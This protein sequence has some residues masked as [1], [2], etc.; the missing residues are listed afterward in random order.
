MTADA[1]E[2]LRECRDVVAQA[3]S[4]A[5]P[6]LRDLLK[7]ID[8]HLSAPGREEARE[9]V[10]IRKD[11]YDFLMG[12]GDLD[13]KCLGQRSEGDSAFWWR[14][15]LRSNFT[16]TSTPPAPPSGGQNAVP[17]DRRGGVEKEAPANS[18]GKDRTLN[19]LP[20]GTAPDEGVVELIQEIEYQAS[21]KLTH[22]PKV[23]DLLLRAAAAL[24]RPK[25]DR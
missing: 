2:L 18:L 22:L 4:W 6:K 15:H 14:T 25:G 8:A 10:L 12:V 16:S 19:D 11:V 7:R 1:R 13:G 24:T 17:Q 23:R 9:M 5:T 21:D 20:A 3:S